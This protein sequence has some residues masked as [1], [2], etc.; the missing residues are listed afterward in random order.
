MIV[1]DN[2][3]DEPIMIGPQSALGE[4]TVNGP[5]VVNAG[6]TTPLTVGS[7]AAP[8]T[9][10][11]TISYQNASTVSGDTVRHNLIAGSE[12]LALY[13][14]N[15]NQSAA[16]ITN[17]PAA[18]QAL[19][20]TLGAIPI[21]FGTNNTYAGQFD[22]SQ[23]LQVVGYVATKG[24]TPA[25]AAGTTAIGTTTTTTVITTAGGVAIPVLAATMWVVNV[26]GVQYGIPC[27]AL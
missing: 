8:V 3:F 4:L 11:M 5:L 24:A 26:N 1:D 14:S 7:A 20:R 15:Q 6:T 13:L 25:V 22:S 18:P 16:L 10:A 19:I 2:Q 23:N 12:A 9:G 27:F 17:G 21:V